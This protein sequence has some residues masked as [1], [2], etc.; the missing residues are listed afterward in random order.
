MTDNEENNVIHDADTGIGEPRGGGFWNFLSLLLLLGMLAVIGVG[1]LIYMQPYTALNPY[2]PPT[3]P[4]L[5][6]LP[7]DT[8]VPS[9]IPSQAPS[10]LIPVTDTPAPTLTPG[11]ATPIGMGGTAA[12]ATA[13]VESRY[14]FALQSAPQAISATVLYP[15]RGC[16]W[17]GV[18]GQVLDLQGR[19]VPGAIVMLGG[20]L[21]DDQISLNSMTGT[22]LQFGP[23]G[24]EFTLGDMP[25]A[26]SGRLWVR[27]VDQS[28]LPLS[29]RV[30]FDTFSDCTRN[31]IV[32]NFK[33]VK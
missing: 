9:A 19:G 15:D 7:S 14:A 16:S 23:A 18:G 25:V 13:T 17:M 26:S 2:P 22:A 5:I 21:G 10:M 3:L 6:V 33:Q 20:S 32:I 31:L 29:E 24:Y 4:A 27:L 30:Y 11:F 1:V 12:G 8:P 28:N